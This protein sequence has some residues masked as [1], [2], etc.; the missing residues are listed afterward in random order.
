MKSLKSHFSLTLA[1]FAILFSVQ[2]YLVAT[3]IVAHYEERLKKSYTIIVVSH[4]QLSLE[5]LSSTIS[6]IASFDKLSPDAILESLQEDLTSEQINNL[7]ATLPFYYELKLDFFPRPSQ[8]ATLEKK[9]LNTSG[10]FQ[11]ENFSQ[12]HDQLFSMLVII[13]TIMKVFGVLLIVVALLLILKEMRLW[14]FQHHTRMHIMALF[15]APV[16]LRS[17]VLFRFA[18]ID[19]IIA[20]LLVAMTFMALPYYEPIVLFLEALQISVVFL[21]W[22]HEVPLLLAIALIASISLALMVMLR[23]ARN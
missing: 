13:K 2:T 16:W 9:L 6:G 10:V 8:V 23:R 12:R 21:E 1:L 15:G 7:K 22:Q 17:A 4:A 18:F 5:T 11:V 19:A 3:K 14:Q 20:T